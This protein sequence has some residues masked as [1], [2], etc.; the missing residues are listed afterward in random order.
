LFPALSPLSPTVSP[1]C[2]TLSFTLSPAESPTVSTVSRTLSSALSPT[3]SPTVFHL[4]P[5]CPD[6][7]SPPVSLPPRCGLPIVSQLC[8]LALNLKPR[9]LLGCKAG[10]SFNYFYL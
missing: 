4:S 5:R 1:T 6:V 3:V 7:V 2:L 10:L 8:L 9:L